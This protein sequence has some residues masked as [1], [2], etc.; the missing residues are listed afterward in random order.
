MARTTALAADRSHPNI[1]LKPEKAMRICSSTG[2]PRITSMKI[3]ET[4]Q[5]GR[6]FKMEKRD[7]RIQ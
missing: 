7:V 4:T 1:I 3:V 2:V 5:R 6:T